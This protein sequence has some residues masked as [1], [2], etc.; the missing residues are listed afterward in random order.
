MATAAAAQRRNRK[1]SL[2]VAA[3]LAVAALITVVEG[4]YLRAVSGMLLA[5]G[6]AVQALASPTR[7]GWMKIGLAIVIVGVA[8][9][10]AGLV[11]MVRH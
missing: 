7:P 5:I 3:L 10:V 8:G 4:S 2:F 9:T 11:R 1:L 6:M